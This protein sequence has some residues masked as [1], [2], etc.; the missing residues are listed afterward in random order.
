MA[1]I[2]KYSKPEKIETNSGIPK[3]DNSR[4]PFYYDYHTERWVYKDDDVSRTTDTHKGVN[5]EDL[6]DEKLRESVDGYAEKTYWGED[7]EYNDEDDED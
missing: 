1:I 3:Y 2:D 7:Y 4:E 5:I 6:I